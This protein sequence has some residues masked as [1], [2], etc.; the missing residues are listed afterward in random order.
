MSTL[1]DQIAQAPETAEHAVPP[2]RGR[3]RWVICGL[4]FAAVVLSYIDR[5][6][7]G[8]L[9]PD[10]SAQYGWSNTGYGDIT[11]YFQV[12]YGFGFLF[13]GWLVDRIGARV[14]YLLAM[15]T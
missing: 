3:V 15:V 13:F 1:G 5:L 10:L 9:K 14:G 12:C 11:G 4:L 6:V 8:V 7:L 2:P